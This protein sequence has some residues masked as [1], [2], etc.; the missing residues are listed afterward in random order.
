MPRVLIIHLKR[1]D[2]IG[3]KIK[4]YISYESSLDL[5]NLVSDNK[6][7]SH[8][9]NLI[10][11]VI[12]EGY[13]TNSGHYYCYVKNSNGLWY[14]IN[15]SNVSQVPLSYVLKQNPYLLFYEKEMPNNEFL[16]PLPLKHKVSL[17]SMAHLSIN[18]QKNEVAE[19]NGEKNKQI[20][21][22]NKTNEQAN[23]K[24]NNKVIHFQLTN[25]YRQ[26]I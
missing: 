18:N 13:S 23:G 5:S 3:K 12:H 20:N 22:I 9:Y 15:D 1:F 8:K 14:C 17:P 4:K 11:M 16:M 24:V 26:E 21:G 2:N 6:R 25:I 19:P 10:S 7:E